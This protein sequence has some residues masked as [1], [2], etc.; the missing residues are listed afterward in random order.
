MDIRGT[1][2]KPSQCRARTFP[3]GVTLPFTSPVSF[4]RRCSHSGIG[5]RVRVRS[6]P[7]PY[8]RHRGHRGPDPKIRV[9]VGPR[10]RRLADDRPPGPSGPLGYG[11]RDGD[12]VASVSSPVGR[13]YG[14]T[15]RLRQFECLGFSYEN[16]SVLALDLPDNDDLDGLLG[17]NF[18][19]EFDYEICSKKG[20]LRIS[21]A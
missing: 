21:P 12:R 3:K 15:I 7:E 1:A 2:R 20:I 4:G 13:E 16:F 8:S 10:H 5:E 6:K 9:P 19:K 11:A 18:L 17:W 14:Y